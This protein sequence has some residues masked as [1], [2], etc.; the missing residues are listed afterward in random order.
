MTATVHV[1]AAVLVDD[2]GR[3]LVVRKHGATV[4]QQPGGK[5]DPGE[6]ALD[7][8]VREVAEETGI[9]A[10]RAAFEPLGRFTDAAA[11]EPGHLVVADAYVLRVAAGSGTAIP[12]AEIA[13]LRWIG[14]HEVEA[15]PLAPLSRNQ[16][17]RYAWR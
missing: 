4:F 16:L 6:T 8:V 3:A 1:S 17:I 10:D 14:E 12:A 9:V 2:A 13:E 11:N 15:T 5:P 7:A